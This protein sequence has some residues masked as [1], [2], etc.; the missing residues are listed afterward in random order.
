M[1]ASSSG[2]ISSVL[3]TDSRGVPTTSQR[4]SASVSLNGVTDRAGLDEHGAAARASARRRRRACGRCPPAPRTARCCATCSVLRRTLA[5]APAATAAAPKRLGFQLPAEIGVEHAHRVRRSPERIGGMED[6][7]RHDRQ[8]TRC[9]RSGRRAV[10]PY[11]RRPEVARRRVVVCD[12]RGD[13]SGAALA[14]TSFALAYERTRETASAPCR[15]DGQAIHVAAP[16]IAG[17]DQR[18][19][20]A[21]PGGPQRQHRRDVVALPRVPAGGGAHRTSASAAGAA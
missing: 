8:P 17:G 7:I 3:A 16:A 4:A 1:S 19:V 13:A 2:V 14:Q 20:P 11:D 5:R 15:I 12:E 10:V 18:G 6:A 9:A 21:A